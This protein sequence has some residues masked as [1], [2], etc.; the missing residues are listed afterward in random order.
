[1]KRYT[2]FAAAAA[3]A[4]RVLVVGADAWAAT[5]DASGSGMHWRPSAAEPVLAEPVL[6]APVLVGATAQQ[7]G[8]A[9][10]AKPDAGGLTPCL[11]TCYLGPRVGPEYNEGRGIATIEWV[12]LFFF[13]ARIVPAIQAYQGKTMTEWAKETEIDTRPIPPPR[14]ES[15]GKG[16]MA[17]FLLGCYLGPR[18]AFER[19]EGRRVRT[20][21]ILLFIP[22][23][24][25]VTSV[26]MG[27]E[28]YSGKTMTQIAQDEG[29]DG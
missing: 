5:P 20:R 28:A 12:S 27:L 14:G 11:L 7:A 22:V 18:V 26:L 21:E 19:N 3:M 10:N 23:V 6:A 15:T 1:M 24:N 16:G 29:L 4:A 25:V 2:A 9:L 8:G 17:G 13:P